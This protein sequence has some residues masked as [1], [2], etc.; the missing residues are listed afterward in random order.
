MLTEVMEAWGD[1]HQKKLPSTRDF[2][3]I[4]EAWEDFLF[5]HEERLEKQ[6]HEANDFQTTVRGVKI[7]GVYSTHRE[8]AHRARQLA[9][10][11]KAF[12]V[13][14]GQVG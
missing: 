13:Y 7:R 11:D 9:K 14:V 5:H 8:A 4:N 6:F 12:D 3:D 2:V 10:T 1:W